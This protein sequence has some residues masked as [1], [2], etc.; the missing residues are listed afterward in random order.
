MGRRHSEEHR[1][2][3]GKTRIA[4]RY[5]VERLRARATSRKLMLL[6]SA[7]IRHAPFA[8]CGRTIWELL[9]LQKWNIVIPAPGFI[10]ELRSPDRDAAIPVAAEFHPFERGD[11][12]TAVTWFENA[13]DEPPFS[14]NLVKAQE[15]F[16]QAE[17]CAEA[18]RFETP[19]NRRDELE[20]S[21]GVAYWLYG[22]SRID[23]APVSKNIIDYYLASYD[24]LFYRWAGERPHHGSHRTVV[25]DLINDIFGNPFRPVAFD[26][27]WRTSTAVAIAK[28]MYDSRDFSAMPIL[29][30]AL[31]DAGCNHADILDHCRGAGPHVRGCWVVDLVL[32]KS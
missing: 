23:G 29:A 14:D 11:G 26:P 32:N 7:I 4:Q 17:Y 28:T 19:E 1:V 24:G 31:E 16:H 30:D 9:P 15:Y 5:A 18:D 13:S 6:E 10:R 2:V 22:M 12:Q 20:V 27:S 8:D 3:F 25:L 21:Y